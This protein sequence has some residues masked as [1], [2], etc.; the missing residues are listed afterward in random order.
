MNEFGFT[1]SFHRKAASLQSRNFGCFRGSVREE[2]GGGG[3]A[4]DKNVRPPGRKWK[5]FQQFVRRSKSRF[6]G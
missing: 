1:F 5:L 3:A 2:G 6:N 4:A